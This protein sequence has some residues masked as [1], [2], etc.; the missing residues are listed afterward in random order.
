[1][2]IT[3]LDSIHLPVFYLKTRRF[4]DWI[5]SPSPGGTELFLLGPSDLDPIQPR[6]HPNSLNLYDLCSH[7]DYGDTWGIPVKVLYPYAISQWAPRS[8]Y[9]TSYI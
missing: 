6:P 1:M 4:R 8:A 9:L 3:I 7:P 2:T 5:L